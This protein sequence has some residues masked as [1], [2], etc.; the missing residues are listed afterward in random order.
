MTNT[1]RPDFSQENALINQRLTWLLASQSILF[2]GFGVLVAT[3]GS[4][5]TE[6]FLEYLTWLGI[7]SCAV[8]LFGIFAAAFAQ[9]Y[10]WK[11]L[12]STKEG[13]LVA[14]AERTRFGVRGW[15]TI[16]GL[17]AAMLLPSLFLAVWLKVSTD[18]SHIPTG[19]LGKSTSAEVVKSSSDENS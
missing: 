3:G 18:A 19:E 1:K 6:N 11:D 14:R 9:F 17:I 10:I 2:A 13:V 16:S 7:G 12:N 5:A 15:T 8:I 4:E